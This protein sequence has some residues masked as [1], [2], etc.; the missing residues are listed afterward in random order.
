MNVIDGEEE[1]TVD[2]REFIN[3]SDDEASHVSSS[4]KTADGSQELLSLPPDSEQGVRSMEDEGQS[5]IA[6]A[7]NLLQLG[8][9]E[10]DLPTWMVK[11]GQWRY[12]ASTAGGTAWENLLKIYMIQERRLEFT[13][14]VRDLTRIFL[15]HSSE[16]IEGCVPHE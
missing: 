15:I 10:T 16:Q 1:I 2:L 3:L 14:T 4:Q 8:V 13:E 5:Q 11:K 12:V 6:S 9:D 7:R